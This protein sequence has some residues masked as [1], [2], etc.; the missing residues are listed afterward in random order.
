M[1]RLDCLSL[2]E[3]S[4]RLLSTGQLRRLFLARALLG[5]PDI[6]LLDEP[7][8]G[9]DEHGRHQ[10]LALLDRLATQGIHF[11]FVSHLASDGPSCLN[12]T[13]HMENGRL[14]IVS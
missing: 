13:A 10:Y 4:I 5:G 3:T 8:S 12:R 1:R 2:A 9:L 11:V 7:C 14:R 6:L